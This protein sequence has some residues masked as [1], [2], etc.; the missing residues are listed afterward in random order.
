MRCPFHVSTI[1]LVRNAAK[2]NSDDDCSELLEEEELELG[3]KNDKEMIPR[4]RDWI[5]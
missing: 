3:G 4:S 1:P 5:L 2:L